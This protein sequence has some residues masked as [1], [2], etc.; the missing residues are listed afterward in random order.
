MRAA[1][2]ASTVFLVS[3]TLLLLFAGVG[4][5]VG[6]KPQL[7]FFVIGDWGRQG[8]WNQSQV[9]I[10]MG[11]KASTLRPSFVISTGDNMYPNGLNSTDDPLFAQSF[12]S[13]YVAPSLQVP[14]YAVLGNHDWGDGYEY[15][16]NDATVPCA[17]GPKYQLGA[18]LPERDWRWNCERSYTKRFLDDVVEIFFVD[19]STFISAYRNVSWAKYDGGILQQNWELQLKEIESRLAASKALWKIMVGHH[20]PR[21]NGN[22][23]N[24]SDIMQH[25]EPL[26]QRYGVKVFFEGHD[27]NLE[28]LHLLDKDLH[29]F[30][31]GGGSD[32][33]RGFSTTVQSK[34]QFPSSGFA[35]ATVTEDYLEVSFYNLEA[36]NKASY[37]S[38]LARS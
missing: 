10:L 12:S 14:W 1:F 29:I 37:T 2:V 30:V 4:T 34:Y 35:A 15:C 22:H 23:G 33:D 6:A 8:T 20:P 11:S 36:G 24:N 3:A 17:R 28:H 21:S 25:L 13:V 38:R 9:A 31:S 19:T 5:V 32:C 16:V 18:E 26:M 27:H 7:S